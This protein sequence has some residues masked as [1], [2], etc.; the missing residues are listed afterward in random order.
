[1][2]L[3][4]RNFLLAIGLAFVLPSCATSATDTAPAETAGEVECFIAT[5]P[6]SCKLEHS[7][8]GGEAIQVIGTDP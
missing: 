7:V 3:P 4:N 5:D 8:A 2:F 1:M 6:I